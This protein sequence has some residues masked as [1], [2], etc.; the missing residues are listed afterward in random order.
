MTFS[1][2]YL[3]N[4]LGYRVFDF[5]RD[6]YVGGF[7]SIGRRMMSVLEALDRYFSWKI[8]L[9]NLFQPLYQDYSLAGRFFGIVFRPI[10]LFFGSLV[11]ICVIV[12]AA[13]V[14]ICWAAIPM[15][16]IY[17]GFLNS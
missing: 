4:R 1:V 8:T 7:L 3:I 9:K 14:Y 10:R 13:A 6:W 12:I 16:V 17:N 2:F 11:Y 5:V 15:L